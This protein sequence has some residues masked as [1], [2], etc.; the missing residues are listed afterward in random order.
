MIKIFAEMPLNHHRRWLGGIFHW[1]AEL[2]RMKNGRMVFVNFGGKPNLEP[3][4]FDKHLPVTIIVKDI[5]SEWGRIGMRRFLNRRRKKATRNLI[6][7]PAADCPD[8]SYGLGDYGNCGCYQIDPD[9]IKA[10]WMRRSGPV[11]RWRR[12]HP[13]PGGHPSIEERTARTGL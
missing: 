2:L 6:C 11:S 13:H 9:H 8:K 4:P 5:I 1:I 7:S 10:L 12:V 3:I